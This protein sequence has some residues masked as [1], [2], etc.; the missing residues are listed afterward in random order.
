MYQCDPVCP[1]CHVINCRIANIVCRITANNRGGKRPGSKEARG[2]IV[3]RGLVVSDR[4]AHVKLLGVLRRP[5]GGNGIC[6]RNC[7][8]LED[9]VSN[10]FLN[11]QQRS[12]SNGEGILPPPTT[13]EAGLVLM[14]RAQSAEP[15]W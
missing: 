7:C 5:V 1:H 4:R 12:R 6:D 3:Y 11:Q 15:S 8:D 14:V 13:W 2:E 10:G 9:S